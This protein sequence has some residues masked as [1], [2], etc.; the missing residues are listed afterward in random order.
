ML[1]PRK[2]SKGRAM[3]SLHLHSPAQERIARIYIHDANT[4]GLYGAHLLSRRGPSHRQSRP[5]VRPSPC[6]K[7]Q[8]E[9]KYP[10]PANHRPAVLLKITLVL[11][12]IS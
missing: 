12:P 6:H 2:G 8:R 4:C 11:S 5:H 3:S 9:G 1:R 7:S 10:R